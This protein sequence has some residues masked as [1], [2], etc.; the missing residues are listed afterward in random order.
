MTAGAKTVRGTVTLLLLLVGTG[1]KTW[2]PVRS[3][4]RTLLAEERPSSV[5]LTSSD[6][7]AMILRN[8]VLVNDSLVSGAAP[9]PNMVVVPARTGVLADEVGTIE[10]PRFSAGRSAA[11]AAAILGASLGWAR[12]QGAGL[13]REDR[14]GPLPKD[15]AFDVVGLVRFLVGVF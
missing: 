8:P 6:G 9:P 11:F 1:C 15:P 14:P 2:E 3:D 5:R 7:R 13:G 12:L 4:L 10:V